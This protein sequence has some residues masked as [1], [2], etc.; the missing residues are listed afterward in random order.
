[1]ALD[2]ISTIASCVKYSLFAFNLVF[3]VTGI[4]LISVG[5][6]VQA[7]YHV[8]SS[9][10]DTPYTSVPALLIAIGVIIFI[11]AFFGCC[12]AIKENYC[13]TLTFSILLI[14]VFIL[15]L[16]AGISGY[17]LRDRTNAII[18][19]NLRASL[20]KYNTTDNE[21]LTRIWDDM[22]RGFGCCGVEKPEDW[23][24]IINKTYPIS[25]CEIES[26]MI[27]TLLCNKEHHPSLYNNGCG[28]KMVG[29]IKSH[30]GSLGAAAVCIAVL[31]FVGIIGA[32]YLAKRSKNE[33]IP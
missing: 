15:E 14:L 30:A 26:G 28:S 31:Q 11:V 24:E 19:N 12:G 7:K 23:N 33:Y 20:N 13:M 16:A 25:C 4:I 22:Q 21:D 8:Y 5:A 2:F 18:T 32:C 17:V 6:G 1:M 10:L 27:G 9:L 3:V 29:I